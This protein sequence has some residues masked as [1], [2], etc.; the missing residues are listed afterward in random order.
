MESGNNPQS[1]I[2]PLGQSPASGSYEVEVVRNLLVVSMIGLLLASGSFMIFMY[3][4]MKM[5]RGQL[6]EQRPSV[7]KAIQDYKSVSLPLIERFSKRMQGYAATHPDFKPILQRYEPVLGEFMKNSP[8]VPA[9]V[10]PAAPQ[11]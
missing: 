10:P 1:N 2:T 7:Q 3:Q 6:A 8:L 9:T 4:Q 11:K 5:V